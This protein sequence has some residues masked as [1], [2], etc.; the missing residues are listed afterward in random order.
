MQ[1][2]TPNYI[3]SLA[4]HPLESRKFNLMLCAVFKFH[5]INKFHLDILNVIISYTMF[6][7]NSWAIIHVLHNM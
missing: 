6:P 5:F 1:K 2:Y 4:E 3:K 7:E